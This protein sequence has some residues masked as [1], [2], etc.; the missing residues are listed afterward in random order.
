M[1]QLHKWLIFL[2]AKNYF[3][4]IDSG[5]CGKWKFSFWEKGFKNQKAGLCVNRL[6]SEPRIDDWLGSIKIQSLCGRS[7]AYFVL[8]V[9]GGGS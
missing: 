5:F 7:E 4:G 9:N 1:P 3:K 6:L 2:L 8:Q